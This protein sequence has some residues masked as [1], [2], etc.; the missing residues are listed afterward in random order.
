MSNQIYCSKCGQSN[1]LPE[2][3]NSMFCAFCGCSIHEAQAESKNDKINILSKPQI[4]KAIY[5]YKPGKIS[6]A[7]NALIY[8]RTGEHAGEYSGKRRRVEGGFEYWTGEDW[9]FVKD[10]KV[11]VN[12][13]GELSLVNKNINNF[14]EIS[15]WFSDSELKTI[16]K[17]ILSNN[18]IKS[19]EGV[20]AFKSIKELNLSSN[21]IEIAEL[22]NGLKDISFIDVIILKDNPFEKNLPNNFVIP[23]NIS[24]DITSQCIKCGNNRTEYMA[25]NFGDL[26]QSCCNKKLKKKEDE[27]FFETLRNKK[28]IREIF[29]KQ[30]TFGERIVNGCFIATATMGSY[31]HPTVMELRHFR[32]NWILQKSWGEGFVKWY[33]HYGAIAAKFIEKSSILKKISYLCIVKPLVYLSRIVKK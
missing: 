30:P 8:L 11:V 13:G 23:N 3:K 16:T 21:K 17:L 18:N 9:H 1:Q 33:Y 10:K 28:E 26:C 12:P 2:G 14:K 20:S 4:S 19:F 25:N 29:Y 15:Q 22:I 32:D 27:E 24:F 5:K 31:E 7:T 6:T